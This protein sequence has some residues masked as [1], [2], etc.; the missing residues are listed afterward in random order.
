MK[1]NTLRKYADIVMFF[2]LCFLLGTGLMMQYR[3]VPGYRGGHGWT[4]L[5]L[6]RHEWGHYHLW[7]AY[8]LIALVVVH[9]VLN[10]A[11]VRNVVASRRNWVLVVLGLAGLIIALFFL[12]VPIER[13]E[14]GGH[15]GGHGRVR[16][17]SLR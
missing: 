15:G 2:V 7:A 5:G 13:T 6:T 11:F 8:L 4:M 9:L 16:I 12:L 10:Y 1:P 14:G 17:S 3:L